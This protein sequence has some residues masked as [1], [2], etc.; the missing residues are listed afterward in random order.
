MGSERSTEG[1][2]AMN[3]E[4][5]PLE[6]ALSFGLGETARPMGR[7][8]ELQPDWD[9]VKRKAVELRREGRTYEQIAEALSDDRRRRTPWWVYAQLNPHKSPEQI[10]AWAEKHHPNEISWRRDA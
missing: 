5:L 4:P 9:G 2:E 8:P 6:R 7:E 1:V 3:R 10:A